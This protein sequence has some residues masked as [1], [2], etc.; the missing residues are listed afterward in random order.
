MLLYRVCITCK[1]AGSPLRL[2]RNPF[3]SHLRQEE[4]KKERA[5]ETKE[6]NSHCSQ[7]LAAR[8]SLVAAQ[9]PRLSQRRP[10]AAARTHRGPM[11]SAATPSCRGTLTILASPRKP[12]QWRPEPQSLRSSLTTSTKIK[13]R[14]T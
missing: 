9:K 4:G 8:I 14:A 7:P 11:Y 5:E 3:F 12:Q 13:P 2:A 6:K 1:P 10:L